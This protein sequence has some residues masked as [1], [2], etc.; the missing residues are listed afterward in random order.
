MEDEH[1]RTQLFTLMMGNG[2]AI[3]NVV[4][5]VTDGSLSYNDTSTLSISNRGTQYR[6]A[7]KS[8]NII[9]SVTSSATLFTLADI[10]ASPTP[11]PQV[12]SEYTNTVQIKVNF[13][14]SNADIGGAQIEEQ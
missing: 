1:Y 12:D 2:G 4:V 11:K 9:G 3:D 10:P 5:V 8:S 7:V 14:N 13:V 6:V